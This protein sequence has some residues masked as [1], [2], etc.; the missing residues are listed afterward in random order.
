VESWENFAVIV[1]GAAAALLGLLFIAISIRVNLVAASTE[2]RSR[3]AQ[4]LV[5]FGAVLVVAILLV[6]PEQPLPLLG[7]E[8]VVLSLGMGVGL[9]VLERRAGELTGDQRIG[10]IL[11]LVSPNTITALPLLAAGIVLICGQQWG[12]YVLVVP[13]LAAFVGGLTNAWL[14]MVRLQEP[15]V[16]R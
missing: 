16:R 13:V 1:G 3:A 7:A 12:L 15:E 6:V 9:H 4:I 14:F 11:E 5:L 8:F 10:P 2:L